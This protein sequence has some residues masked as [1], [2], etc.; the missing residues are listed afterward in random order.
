VPTEAWFTSSEAAVEPGSVNVLSLM[1]GNLGETTEHYSISLAGM[2][3]GW[4]NARPA[5]LTLL[6]GAYQSVDI[7]VRAPKPPAAIAGASTLAARVIPQHSPDDALS[8]ETSLVVAPVRDLRLMLLPPMHRSRRRASFDLLAENHGNTIAGPRL[9]LHESTGRLDGTI[10]TPLLSV[11]PGGNALVRIRV[12]ARRFQWD[13]RTR[14]IP[15][16]VVATETDATTTAAAGSLVQ[17]PA[18][19]GGGLARLAAVVA[20][21][22]L[23]AGVWSLALG[24]RVDT[25]V[26]RSLATMPTVST[27]EMT[28]P[29]VPVTSQPPPSSA[30]GSLSDRERSSSFSNTLPGAASVGAR[31]LETVE[32]ADGT[33]LLV[34]QVII[35][36]PFGDEGVAVLLLGGVRLEY[37][38]SDLDGVDANQ[39]FVDPVQLP[40]GDVI[41][42]EVSCVVAGRPGASECSASATIIGRLVEQRD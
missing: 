2:A 29:T 36:N 37:E 7:E 3:A 23:M 17:M 32:V 12:R 15:F 10:E 38:L 27:T 24:P 26:Q 39:G 20:A 25:L 28:S 21:V 41:S 16:S 14:S 34:T 18:V 22:G 19:S 4:T 33:E 11:E 42:F 9:H 40:A 35:Q 1:V 31:S 30:E 13:Q 6:P 8:A 5:N